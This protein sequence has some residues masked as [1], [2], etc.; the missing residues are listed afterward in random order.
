MDINKPKLPSQTHTHLKSSC[1]SVC[2]AISLNSMVDVPR[3]GPD[4][5]TSAPDS[6]LPAATE[7]CFSSIMAC[8]E[9]MRALFLAWPPPTTCFFIHASSFSISLAGLECYVNI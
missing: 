2:M 3:R 7:F 9:D 4:G 5:I 1:S 8:A 6:M